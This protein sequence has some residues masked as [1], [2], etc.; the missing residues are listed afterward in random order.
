MFG[1]NV[2]LLTTRIK[3]V[4]SSSLSYFLH[5]NVTKSLCSF[6]CRN[7]CFSTFTNVLNGKVFINKFLVYLM[8]RYYL[9]DFIHVRENFNL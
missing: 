4:D 3:T 2:F 8:S 5:S 6:L 7:E 1:G 9:Y